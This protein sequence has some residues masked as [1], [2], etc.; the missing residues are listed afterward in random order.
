MPFRRSCAG[1]V[2]SEAPHPLPG[3][4]ARE[5]N[6]Q[7]NS[8]RAFLPLAKMLAIEWVPQEYSDRECICTRVISM[9]TL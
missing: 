6:A 3:T 7:I 2:R 4:A 8:K 5:P 9:E 1:R